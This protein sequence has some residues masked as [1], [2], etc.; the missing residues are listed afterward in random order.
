VWARFREEILPGLNV[1]DTE[2]LEN[3]LGKNVPFSFDVDLF[4]QPYTKPTLM[5]MGRQD[6]AT[7]Y[8]DIWQII[9]NY[10]RASFVILDK[11]GH[12]LQIEQDI[13]FTEIVKEWLDRVIEEA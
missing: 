7:G 6:S 4:D 9:E 10:P 5:L 3:C 11:A 13:L 8:R 2:F 12:N 1:A